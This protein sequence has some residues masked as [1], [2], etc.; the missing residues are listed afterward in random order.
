MSVTPIIAQRRPTALRRITRSLLGLR[1]SAAPPGPAGGWQSEHI[2]ADFDDYLSALEKD[3]AQAKRLIVLEVYIFGDDA[4]G[5]RIESALIAAVKRGVRVLVAV[6]GIGSGAWLERAASGVSRQ[7]VHVRVYHPTPWQLTR[8]P[9]PTRQRLA[10]AGRWFRCFNRRNHRKMCAIDGR[11][12]WVGSM[13]LTHEHSA[14]L[15]GDHAWRDT[16]ARVE[17][18][19][20]RVLM[21]A[22]IAAWR[23]SWRVIGP[24]LYP[25]FSVRSLHLSQPLNGL[26]RLN[27][28]LRMR[29]LYYHDLLA[30]ITHA[31]QRVWIANAYF[32]PQG[33]LIKALGAA[34]ANGADVRVIVP[35]QSDVWFMSY[36]AATFA[37]ALAQVGVRLL[38]YQPRMLHAKTMLIDDWVSIGS[39]NLNH[40]SLRHDLEADVVLT[41]P[42][43]L[44]AVENI[45]QEDLAVSLDLTAVSHRPNWR[46]RAIG[47]FM[48]LLRRWI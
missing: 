8:F 6:D 42:A 20:V 33:S 11:L 44:R 2:T 7:G 22:F 34:A 13:N 1:P 36:V 14:A 9:I 47:N 16:V 26:V 12:A 32:V 17:G 21:R 4:I 3:L 23:R 39:T 18:D 15:M 25:S 48:L 28:G 27:H 10:A 37:D 19:G 5:R 35:A 31:R 30:R 38:K 29:R 40:R 43:S 24:R 46:V 45:F 41:T